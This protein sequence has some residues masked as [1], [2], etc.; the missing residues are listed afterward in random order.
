MQRAVD[1]IIVGQGLA[2]TTL[3]WALRGR[4]RRVV[5]IDPEEAVTSSRIAAGLITPVTGQRLVPTWRQQEFWPVACDFY[6]RVEAET[7]TKFF[8]RRSMVRLFVSES[9]RQ[10]YCDRADAELAGLVRDPEQPLNADCFDASLGA[11]EMPDGGRL[12]VATYLDASRAWLRAN[13]A[14]VSGRIDPLRDVNLK[15][16]GV[17]LPGF[18]LRAERLVFCEGAAGRG[19]PWFDSVRFRPAKGEILTLQIPGLEEDRVIHRG[20]WLVRVADDRYMAGST[21]EWEQLD[22]EPTPAGR[23]EICERLRAFLR[24]PF[25]VVG[26]MAAVRPALADFRP[27]LGPHPEHPQLVCFN[28]L[29]AKG[30]LQAPFFARQLAAL[31]AG[32][33][34]ID[35]EVNV[36]RMFPERANGLKPPTA[37]SSGRE[38][39]RQLTRQAHD[40]VR[41]VLAVG[42]VAVDAT[43]GNGHDT[44]LLAQLVGDGGK[45]FAF[46]VQEEAL[47]RT[48]KRLREAGLTHVMLLQRD[49]AELAAAIPVELHGRIAA[50]MFNLGY[51]P[52]GDHSVVT[53]T[54]AT[55]QALE[56]ALE[57]VRPGGVMTVMVYRGHPGGQEEAAAVERLLVDLDPHRWDHRTVDNQSAGTGPR[58]HIV[59]R[60]SPS[61]AGHD[62]EDA[63]CVP[64]C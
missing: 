24:L 61:E 35:D 13:N 22:C 41:E 25:E 59:R 56:A 28:G 3:A 16:D 37:M 49:H 19:N 17:V 43:A 36:L 9:E 46:D 58:L 31:L 23:E 51:L 18:G 54:D 21:Y 6:R 60:R 10:R 44:R 12:D 55:L 30:S 4:G 33:G 34:A 32:E 27:V 47:V 7:K 64:W 20:I 50:V 40:I 26:H 53:R 8:E 63:Q 5:V 29:G 48:E 38:P 1:D 57:L 42:D 11:F 52:G 45:V 15:D 14:M 39:R 62:A 2:G